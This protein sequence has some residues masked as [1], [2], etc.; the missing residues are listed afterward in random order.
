MPG[1]VGAKPAVRALAGAGAIALLVIAVARAGA[2]YRERQRP[3]RRLQRQT[4]RLRSDLG[5][6][7]GQ[8]REAIPYTLTRRADDESEASAQ[9]PSRFKAL[10]WM[11]LTAGLVAL[12]GLAARRLS[13]ALWETVLHEAPPTRRV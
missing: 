1:R 10:L 3:T 5:Q 8:A 4:E 13:A 7:W 2:A 6:R 11:G 12:Y 9:K